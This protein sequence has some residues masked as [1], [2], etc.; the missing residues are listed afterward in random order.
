MYSTRTK[1]AACIVRGLAPPLLIAAAIALGPVLAQQDD[2]G[3]AARV[4]GVG[5]TQE[6]F[7]RTVDAIVRQR[8]LDAQALR[9]AGDY[10]RLR[11][12]VLDTLIGQQLLWQEAKRKG[13]VV[14]EEQVQR[15][16]A[17]IRDS[18]PSEQDYVQRVTAAGFTP[19]T[20]AEDVR[21]RASAR[22]FIRT[23]I[24]PAVEVT[25]AEIGQ[26]YEANRK[27]M[28]TPAQVRAR[29]ILVKVAPEAD[30]Q[31]R[32][33]AREQIDAVL[34]E[35]RAGKD[36]AM[37]AEAHSQGP[38]SSQGGDLG[39][40][41]REQMVKPF[42]D[43]AFA[44]Q[45]GEISGVVQTRFGYH[46]IKL[47][48]RRAPGEV[49]LASVSERIRQGLVAQKVQQRVQEMIVTLRETAEVEVFATP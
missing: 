30:E 48:E 45:P 46:I 3:L 47:E 38:S 41:S 4:N 22:E 27:R 35:A 37:L 43:A 32:A 12:S 2:G 10:G 39:F 17:Q 8:G 28:L 36:F 6:R 7:D 13:V 15:E 25:E 9:E 44:L 40:F 14:S 16:L 49:P 19:E 24:A 34:A 23:T 33:A 21:Q 29:H 18:L 1:P 31:I 11:T 20:F 26:Y 5:I 42:A